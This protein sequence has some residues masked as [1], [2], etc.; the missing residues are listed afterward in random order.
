MNI[1]SHVHAVGDHNIH[2]RS[3][4]Y[5]PLTSKYGDILGADR[6]ISI[7]STKTRNCP[8]QSNDLFDTCSSKADFSLFECKTAFWCSFNRVP[9][10]RLVWPDEDT[11]LECRNGGLGIV[12]YIKLHSFVAKKRSSDNMCDNVPGCRELTNL[13]LQPIFS[14]YAQTKTSS[15]IQRQG[16]CVD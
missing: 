2:C 7:R 10:W 9:N 16:F 4:S 8:T 1:C 3:R 15:V 11:R 12:I 14:R 13:K 5:L 6:L